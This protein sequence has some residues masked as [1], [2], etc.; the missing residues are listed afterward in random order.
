MKVGDLVRYSRRTRSNVYGFVIEKKPHDQVK[1]VVFN[2]D[3]PWFDNPASWNISH[4][5]VIGESR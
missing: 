3:D 4:W 1:V 2:S 5:E